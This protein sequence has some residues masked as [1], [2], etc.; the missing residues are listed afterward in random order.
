MVTNGH[1]K[2]FP[3]AYEVKETAKVE[4]APNFSLT[5]SSNEFMICIELP[6]HCASNSRSSA[7]EVM[8][9]TPVEIPAATAA[10]IIMTTTR[11]R[12][13]FRFSLEAI[14]G[15]ARLVVEEQLGELVLVF[16]SELARSTSLPPSKRRAISFGIALDCL[17]IVLIS[18]IWSSSEKT[19][20]YW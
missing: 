9:N 1:V 3:R 14:S 4:R 10:R 18:E 6:C 12:K 19:A 11:A 13:T 7:C 15:I 20:Q 8:M 5:I 2:L 17:F 16:S